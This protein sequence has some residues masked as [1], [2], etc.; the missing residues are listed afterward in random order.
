MKRRSILALLGL[1]GAGSAAYVASEGVPIGGFAPIDDSGPVD[2]VQ[3][4]SGAE[5]DANDAEIVEWEQQLQSD[6]SERPGY[7]DISFATDSETVEIETNSLLS[8][9]SVEPGEE[10]GDLFRFR[11]TSQSRL[12]ELVPLVEGTLRVSEEV[13]FT[14]DIDD[15]TVSF[16]GGESAIGELAAAIGTHPDSPEVLVVRA[17]EPQQLEAIA[18]SASG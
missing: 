2:G 10:D 15:A 5:T 4:P 18:E 17:S 11:A 12:A 1:G 8:T 3:T 14:T 16:S 7:G 6:L 9:V 13:S